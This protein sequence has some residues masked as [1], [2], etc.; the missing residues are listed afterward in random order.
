MLKKRPSGLVARA[1]ERVA[2]DPPAML[3]E[4]ADT[5]ADEA[6]GA[7]VGGNVEVV[8]HP[9]IT[10]TLALVGQVG[11]VADVPFADAADGDVQDHFGGVFAWV[12]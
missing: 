6:A 7:R 5:L 4:R 11:D 9:V 3:L 8:I 12:G 10:A 2:R 1:L